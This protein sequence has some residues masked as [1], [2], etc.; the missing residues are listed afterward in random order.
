MK[1]L[2]KFSSTFFCVLAKGICPVVAVDD[3][4]DGINSS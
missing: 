2:Y 3:Y 1:D 4:L